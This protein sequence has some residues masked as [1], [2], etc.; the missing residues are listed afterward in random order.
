MISC[1]ASVS[2]SPAPEH[3]AYPEGTQPREL[4][5]L[6]VPN[7]RLMVSG[8]Y[9]CEADASRASRTPLPAE[10]S[11]SRGRPVPSAGG[12]RRAP[13]A[14]ALAQGACGPG[15]SAGRQAREQTARGENQTEE[16]EGF[17]YA[18]FSVRPTCH[19]WYCLNSGWP[20][21]SDLK[22]L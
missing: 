1:Q 12:S 3:S 19:L 4:F 15:T 22:P 9:S 6:F 2:S 5:C 18:V 13:A 16:K 14:A 17:A 21:S 11:A 8:S 20:P 7:C 10:G